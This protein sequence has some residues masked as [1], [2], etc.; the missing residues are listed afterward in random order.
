MRAGVAFEAPA[1]CEICRE[2]FGRYDIPLRVP[3]PGGKG[4]A[5]PE[6]FD[7]AAREDAER[8]AEPRDRIGELNALGGSVYEGVL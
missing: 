2:E 3:G 6:C 5:H 1:R 8:V 4:W 7:Q